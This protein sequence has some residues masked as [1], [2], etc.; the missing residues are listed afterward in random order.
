VLDV[1]ILKLMF[2][3]EFRLHASFFNRSFF[4]FSSLVIILFIL[5]SPAFGQK[6]SDTIMKILDAEAFIIQMKS[7]GNHTLIDVRTWMEY[8][9]G[10]ARICV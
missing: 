7:D 9:K 4:P 8:K 10:R 2:K 3:E 6:E 5:V 1:K